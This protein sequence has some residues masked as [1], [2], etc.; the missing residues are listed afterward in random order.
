MLVMLV[1]MYNNI[2]IVT[3]VHLS[4]NLEYRASL[5]KSCVVGHPLYKMKCFEQ[6]YVTQFLLISFAFAFYILVV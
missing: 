3:S 2:I 1:Y 5:T 6:L 4:S